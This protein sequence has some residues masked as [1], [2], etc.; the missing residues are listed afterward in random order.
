MKAFQF[1]F[2]VGS[3]HSIVSTTSYDEIIRGQVIDA[4]M[5]NQGERAFR[6]TYGCDIRAAL[7]DPSDSLVRSDASNYI[8]DRLQTFVPRIVVGEIAFSN[9]Y[10][11]EGLVFIDIKYRPSIV[12]DER[13]IRVSVTTEALTQNKGAA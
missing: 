7:F 3:N 6:G 10:F 1:P 8:K 9:E 12:Q 11:S 5:T 4:V 13:S 2:T